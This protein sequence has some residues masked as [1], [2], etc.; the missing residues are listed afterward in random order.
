MPRLSIPA[1]FTAVAVP[2][3]LQIVSKHNADFGVM[4]LGYGF[5]Q[6]TSF[7]LQRPAI[8]N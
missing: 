4:Q 7:G 8:C 5:E 6:A 2:I 1:G 3:G